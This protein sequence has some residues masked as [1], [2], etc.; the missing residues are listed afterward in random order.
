M[1]VLIGQLGF[2]LL[3]GIGWSVTGPA[4]VE[5]ASSEARCSTLAIAYNICLGLFGGTTPLVATYLV[6]RTA[7]DFAPVYYLMAAAA[8]SFISLFRV[9]EMKGRALPGSGDVLPDRSS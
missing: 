1:P 5:L 6:S 2:A 9:P 4:M 3:N 8:L 7:D